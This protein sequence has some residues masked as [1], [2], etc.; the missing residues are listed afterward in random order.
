MPSVWLS[1]NQSEPSFGLK[2]WP[3]ELRMPVA[4]TSRL[5]PSNGFKRI[6][7]PMPCFLYSSSLSLGGTLKG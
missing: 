6:I 4:Y 3:T 5:L 2:S 1:V 7:P